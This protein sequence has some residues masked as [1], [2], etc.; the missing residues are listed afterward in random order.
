MMQTQPFRLPRFTP[1]GVIEK[2]VELATGL[3]QLERYYQQRPTTRDGFEFMRYTLEALNVHYQVDRGRVEQI[4][5]QGPVVIVA[6]HPLGAIEGVILAD[7]VGQVRKDV[8]VLA[9]QLLKR[10]P[11]IEP[12]FIGVDVFNGA[13]ASKTNARGIR[14]AHRHLAEGGVLIVFPAGE[15]STPQKETGQLS[16]IDWSQSVAKF[17]QRSQATCV[18]IYIHG[19]NSAWFY[20]AG[21]IH[22]L[23]RTAMLGRELLNKSASTISLCIGQ[24]IPYAELKEFTK[25]EDVVNYLR[26]NTYLMSPHGQAESAEVSFTIPVIEPVPKADLIAELAQLD[27]QAKLLEQGEFTVYCVP[28]THIPLMMQEIGRVREISFRAVGE[29][30]GQACDVD[31]YDHHYWQLFVWNREQS[32]LVGAYR[33][34]LVDKIVAERGLQGLYSRSLFHYDHAFLAT[35]EN[36][37]ELGRS[38]VAEQ[39]QRNL[40]SLLLLWKGIARFVE[41][42]PHYTH[43]FGPVSI[44]NDYSPAARQLMA[45]TLSIH[46]YDQNKAALVKPSTP[47]R[48]GA[49]VFWQKSLLSALASVSLLSKVVARMEQGNGLPVLLRQYLGMNGKLV[50]FNVDPAFNDALDGLIVVNLK[51]VP[52]K[53]LAKYMGKEAAQHYLCSVT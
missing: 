29:G 26:L 28:S 40:N 53:T 24:P 44:S 31:A 32:E 36:A 14:E 49:E 50:C 6:N 41:L 12:L 30:S 35:L 18:P 47:L 34:G 37:I 25:D 8:K 10:L 3:S 21:K 15:V 2:G 20:R 4:P 51:Q 23:L 17:I 13:Q 19:R 22:P 45:A 9:N 42:N 33:M 1:F 5:T 38:V 27:K 16:D 7:L 43:L 46:H 39:Y 11:E 52:L 48:A